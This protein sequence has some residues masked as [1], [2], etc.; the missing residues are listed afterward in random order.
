M[1]TTGFAIA[2]KF[3]IFITISI[4]ML[5]ISAIGY[6]EDSENG[7]KLNTEVQIG[8]EKIIL[9]PT[10]PSSKEPPQNI[11]VSP[12]MPKPMPP[13]PRTTF[14]PEP[15]SSTQEPTLG[16]TVTIPIGSQK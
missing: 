14:E 5:A 7:N 6:A 3:R 10:T 13:D 4:M 11:T 15:G 16:V 8:G 12:G 9:S 2:Q 1:H